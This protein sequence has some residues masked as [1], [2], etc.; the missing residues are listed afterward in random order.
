MGLAKCVRFDKVLLN[1]GS[2]LYISLAIAGET[3]SF[4]G[5]GLRYI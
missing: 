4:V 5:R 1:R 3:K 2:F